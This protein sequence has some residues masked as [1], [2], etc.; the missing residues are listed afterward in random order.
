MT[1]PR[2]ISC[3][4]TR[5]I[6]WGKDFRSTCNYVLRNTLEALGLQKYKPRDQRYQK[7]LAENGAIIRLVG[8]AV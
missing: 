6:E 3:P 4:F 5:I 8:L 2:E 7:W 1:L